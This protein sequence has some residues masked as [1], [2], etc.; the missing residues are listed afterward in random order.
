M[1]AKDIARFRPKVDRREP[2]EC[3]AWLGGCDKD[4]YGLFWLNGRQ[5]RVHARARIAFDLPEA[6]TMGPLTL[7][8]CDNPP[9]CNPAHL[10]SGTT[11]MNV[12]DKLRNGRQPKGDT[13][14]LGLRPER[15]AR[16]WS[17]GL[18]HAGG[19]HEEDMEGQR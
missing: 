9:C 7:H 17:A 2:D 16:V 10:F 11:A 13:H 6:N 3:W 5:R 18:R 12:R 1:L 8:A 15:A 14:P 4:G 19:D